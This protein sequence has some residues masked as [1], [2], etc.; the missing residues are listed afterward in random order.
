MAKTQLLV[1]TRHPDHYVMKSIASNEV[2][3]FYKD[4]MEIRRELKVS[5][6][7]HQVAVQLRSVQQK[8]VEKK[9]NELYKSLTE[10]KVKGIQIHAPMQ[11]VVV[12]KRGQYRLNILLQGE[13]VIAMIAFIKAAMAQLKRSSKVIITMNVD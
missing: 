3:A 5:P 6:F 10:Q 12:R 1:Q 9:A 2:D 7:G 11:E 13:D 4:D 8:L